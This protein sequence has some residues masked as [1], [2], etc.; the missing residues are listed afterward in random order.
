MLSDINK[1]TSSHSNE[2]YAALV[3]ELKSIAKKQVRSVRIILYFA[4][5]L[6]YPILYGIAHLSIITAAV[7][8]VAV[9]ALFELTAWIYVLSANTKLNKIK[10]KLDLLSDEGLED[11]LQQ[12]C[13]SKDS[14]FVSEEYMI[15]PQKGKVY[16]LSKLKNCKTDV[17][18]LYGN[19]LLTFK[20]NKS[21]IKLRFQDRETLD[22]A[23]KHI[24]TASSENPFLP[25]DNIKNELKKDIKI[26]SIKIISVLIFSIL[27]FIFNDPICI[28][29]SITF[30]IYYI[31]VLI[32]AIKKPQNISIVREQLKLE[33]NY[34]MNELLSNSKKLSEFVFLSGDHY[35]DFLNAETIRMSDIVYVGEP[36]KYNTLDYSIRV[37]LKCE[38]EKNKYIRSH[39]PVFLNN[40]YQLLSAVVEKND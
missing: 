34:G 33:S 16:P 20:L 32:K 18:E 13:R 12:C 36:V 8:A 25:L 21:K 23:Y 10:E 14:S 40:V 11:Y 38:D 9:I 2:S 22:K 29:V 6:L 37:S 27:S 1:N 31:F 17:N 35:I 7:I 39:D 3:A 5:V 30:L 19:Y 15:R 28:A 24:K 4:I 26:T